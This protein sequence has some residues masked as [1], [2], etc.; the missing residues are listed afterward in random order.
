MI[1]DEVGQL[2][3]REMDGDKL[4]IIKK[5]D[6]KKAL[7]RSPDYLDLLIMRMMFFLRPSQRQRSNIRFKNISAYK[8][9]LGN[10]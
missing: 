8:P 6:M 4:K 2:K 3:R 7:G 5:A 9:Q 1:I 10:R